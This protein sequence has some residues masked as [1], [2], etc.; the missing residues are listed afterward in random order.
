MTAPAP[1]LRQLRA[2]ERR[3]LDGNDPH[4]VPGQL[5]ALVLDVDSEVTSYGR[6]NRLVVFGPSIT[7]P[8]EGER[9]VVTVREDVRPGLPMSTE[10]DRRRVA[11]G[12]Q[13]MHPKGTRLVHQSS[14]PYD[15]R[16]G[17]CVEHTYRWEPARAVAWIRQEHEPCQASTPG[18][19][20]DHALDEHGGCDTW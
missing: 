9:N 8:V 16:L 20:I 6:H 4:G 3:L 12:F 2:K 13:R 15:G 10:E 7:Q 11:S 18:C 19:C 1:T 14:E 17:P 5:N